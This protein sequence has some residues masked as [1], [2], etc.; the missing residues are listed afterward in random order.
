[1]KI[2]L[3]IETTMSLKLLFESRSVAI[4]R[5]SEKYSKIGS[6]IIRS[7]YRL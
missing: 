2:I 7:L 6:A 4:V 5:A 3:P 1:M